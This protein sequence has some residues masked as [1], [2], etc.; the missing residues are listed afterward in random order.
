MYNKRHA[1][2]EID[3]NAFEY[4]V[5]NIQAKVGPQ[6]N[7]I[8]VIKADAYG[9]GAIECARVLR[10]CGVSRFA[11]ATID[12]ALALRQAGFDEKILILGHVPMESLSDIVSNEFTIVVSDAGFAKVMSRLA[13]EQDKQVETMIA[14]DTGMG[15]IGFCVATNEDIKA[16]TEEVAAIDDLPG[17]NV[18]G[19]FS[20]FSTS[21]ETQR[22]YTNLQLRRYNDFYEA[23]AE[24]G[25]NMEF[26]T[27]ANSAAIME[28]PA[29]Y[30]DAVRPGI[31]LY[32]CYPSNEVDK[33]KLSIKPVMQV[34]AR[35]AH[36]KT[37]PAGTS[38]SYGRKFT[39]E[40]ES[41][42]ATITLG[43]ADGYSRRLSGNAEVLVNGH[44]A[45][46]VG[47]ICMDQCMVDVTDIPDVK[48]FDEVVIMGQSG[49]E[50]ITADD[51]AAKLGTINYEITCV[52]GLRLPKVY[53]GKEEE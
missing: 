30:F 38:I 47:N 43:Y 36:L 45:P 24:R 48:L 26:R 44:R 13:L 35:V 21:D 46:V 32:G 2:T 27:I 28:Y 25:V 7:L 22:E 1:W 19:M 33:S 16:A 3:L 49:D 31:I 20:H 18:V 42:I 4:N 11:V 41:K 12:E 53:I 9:H 5:R 14:V 8:G 15:R 51:L 37:V 39:T 23:L 29:A 50:Q 40:R 34:K 17:I 52:F 10:K 6:V